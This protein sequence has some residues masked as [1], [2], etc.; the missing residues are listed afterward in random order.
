MILCPDSTEGSHQLGGSLLRLGV[1]FQTTRVSS[2]GSDSQH[3]QTG[4]GC[5]GTWTGSSLLVSF[6]RTHLS[7][8]DSFKG[9]V[10]PKAR[11][12]LETQH[13]LRQSPPSRH[14]LGSV[15]ET[16]KHPISMQCHD[17]YKNG[18]IRQVA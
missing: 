6:Q 11:L 18:D 5:E 7:F 15:G 14:S 17:Y 1:G 12:A 2:T 3:V 16:S 10:V 4:G 8:T 9:S 13:S